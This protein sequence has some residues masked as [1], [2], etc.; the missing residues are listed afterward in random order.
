MLC[1]LYLAIKKSGKLLCKALC[2]AGL[3]LL[4]VR[5]IDNL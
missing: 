1:S 2:E 5:I 4:N 3:F